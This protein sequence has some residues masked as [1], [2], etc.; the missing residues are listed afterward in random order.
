MKSKANS[1]A[2]STRSLASVR[3]RLICILVATLLVPSL[4]YGQ[5]RP[6][7][8]NEGSPGLTLV[9]VGAAE[10]AFHVVAT[11][12]VGSSESI[13][14]DAQ[15]KVSDGRRLAEQIAETGTTLK[16]VVLS[17]ADHDHY[18]GAMEVIK[19]FPGTPVYMTQAG[20]DDFAARSQGD[21]SSEK[22]RGPNPEV[23]ESLPEP[24]LLP[25]GPLLVDGNEVVVIGGLV[26]DVSA[27]AS[28]A[29]WIPS[30][31]TVLA[32][33]LVF[34]GIHPWLGDSD[35]ASRVAWRESLRRLAALEPLAV[36]PGHKRDLSTPDSPAQIDFMIRYLDH[37][38][39]SMKKAS[40]PAELIEA[41]T[42]EYPDLAIPGLM[43]YGAKQGFKK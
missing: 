32:A 30:L 1:G 26:G 39:A 35:I 18:M 29:L 34:D 15:Y 3:S 38:D 22:Q 36:V 16:A 23:P 5:D 37:Y 33:D 28:T 4:A 10:R 31:K 9:K 19:R 12:I 8:M 43:A 21:W 20:L 7:G 17:H 41:M 25:D 14:W 40:S 24:Q 11:L 6:E 42:T 27:P 13:L 2:R